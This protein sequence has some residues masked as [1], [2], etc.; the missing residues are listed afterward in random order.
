MSFIEIII[1]NNVKKFNKK[2][3][4]INCIKLNFFIGTI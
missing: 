4:E 2:K 1:I 3:K